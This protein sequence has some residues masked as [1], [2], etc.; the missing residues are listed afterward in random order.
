MQPARRPCPSLTEALRNAVTRGVQVTVVIDT[1]QGAA[2]PCPAPSPV[3]P[4][5]ASRASPSTS[6]PRQDARSQTLRSTTAAS[7]NKCGSGAWA[8][9][10]LLTRRECAGGP[11]VHA[12]SRVPF[13]SAAGMPA[14]AR[15]RDWRGQV[16]DAGN[17]AGEA[18]A[19]RDLW[20]RTRPKAV[21]RPVGCRTVETRGDHPVR[22][23]AY[24]R[25]SRPADHEPADQPGDD[26]RLNCTDE[27]S[28]APSALT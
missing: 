24:H 1:S 9:P 2:A 8:L 14:C 18:A 6:G 4:S 21:D 19:N 26:L 7:S 25:P 13:S 10:G 12:A 27:D 23:T 17:T 28:E 3:T 20:T 5:P 11:A 16:A 15:R 22:H